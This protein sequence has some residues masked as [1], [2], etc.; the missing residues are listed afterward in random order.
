MLNVLACFRFQ[1]VKRNVFPAETGNCGFVN[2]R[3]PIVGTD[4]CITTTDNLCSYFV[5]FRKN[6]DETSMTIRNILIVR[7]LRHSDRLNVGLSNLAI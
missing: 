4:M 1:E 2:T 6:D 3:V 5:V 7:I